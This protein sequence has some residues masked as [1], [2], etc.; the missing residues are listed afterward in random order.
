MIDF[1]GFAPSTIAAAAVLCAT[2]GG[3]ELASATGT[4]PVVFHESVNKVLFFGLTIVLLPYWGCFVNNVSLL[5]GSFCS[6]RN[7]KRSLLRKHGKQCNIWPLRLFPFCFLGTGNGEKLSPT[8]GGV[9]DR[10]VFYSS[11]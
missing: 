6:A 9:P 4:L 2:A 5:P 11:P 8:N 3:S 1:L 10:H 7:S